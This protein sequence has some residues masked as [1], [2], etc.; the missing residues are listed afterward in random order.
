MQSILVNM[1]LYLLVVGAG[2]SFALQQ[3]ANNHLRAELVSPWWA[4]F[5]SYI[6]GSAAMLIMALLSRDP[7]LSLEALARTR[8]FSW[9]GGIFGAIY[10]ATA[11]FMI[12]KL[13]ATTVL[14]LMVVGQMLISLFLDH[15]GILG[16][17]VYPV[18]G[19]RLAGVFFLV[20]GVVMVRW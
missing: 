15:Y 10:I 9:A 12:P 6:V 16:I 5:I 11:I 4:G 3:A 2:V 13:G 17:P 14:A 8:P 18:N 1:G 19:V 7:G 20:A